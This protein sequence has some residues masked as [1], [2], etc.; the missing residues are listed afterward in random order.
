M[1]NILQWRRKGPFTAV[2]GTPYMALL[3]PSPLRGRVVVTRMQITVAGTAHTLTVMQVLGKF[4][5]A[6]DA[7]ASQKVVN[8]VAG[9]GFAANDILAIRMPNG[10]YEKYTVDSV[11]TNAVTLLENLSAALPAGSAVCFFGVI[12]DGHEQ[13][14]LGASTVHEFESNEG[15]FGANEMGEPIIMHVG[16]ATAASSIDSINCPIISV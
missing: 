1:L 7:A 5:T 10:R 11:D 3:D 8:M 4:L 15:Y 12:G 16:N 6:S 2:A 9:H 14:A 13:I